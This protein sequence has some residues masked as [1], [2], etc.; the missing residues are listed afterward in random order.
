MPDCWAIKRP[1]PWFPLWTTMV[2][3]KSNIRVSVVL[4]VYLMSRV[5][6]YS[7]QRAIQSNH[8]PHGWL[9]DFHNEP[10]YRS[11]PS[12]I[13]QEL[14][15][16]VALSF[17]SVL[18]CLCPSFFLSFPFFVF[19]SFSLSLYF[20]FSILLF[21]F[22]SDPFSLYFFFSLSIPLSPYCHLSASPFLSFSFYFSFPLSLT[23][24]LC[25]SFPITAGNCTNCLSLW[26]ASNVHCLSVFARRGTLSTAV[27]GE[28]SGSGLWILFPKTWHWHDGLN[29]LLWR[30]LPPKH[31]Q[32]LGRVT[33]PRGVLR[34]CLFFCQF[35]TSHLLVST[36]SAVWIT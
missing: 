2:M 16:V 31:Q 32:S 14:H 4:S 30:W 17:L 18:L 3:G 20:I 22:L 11:F 25:R 12:H 35:H 10:N 33:K 26:D 13:Q 5:H 9:L 6:R 15:S 7:V 29:C 27:W 34:S 28:S 23:C 21:S 8:T 1:R 19:L 24:Y 36:L